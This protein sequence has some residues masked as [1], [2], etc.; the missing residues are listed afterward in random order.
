[1]EKSRVSDRGGGFIFFRPFR[2]YTF[3]SDVFR[4]RFER[5]CMQIVSEKPTFEWGAAIERGR[6]KFNASTY[7]RNVFGKR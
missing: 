7:K 4:F 1:M 5:V 6:V 3:V 2:T